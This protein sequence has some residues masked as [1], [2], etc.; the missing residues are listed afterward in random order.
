MDVVLIGCSKQKRNEKSKAIDL[1][2]SPYFVKRR[3]YAEKVIKADEVFILSAKHKLLAAETMIYPYDLSLNNFTR[4]KRR[5]WAEEVLVQ[6]KGKIQIDDEIFI[7]AGKS[8]YEFLAPLLKKEGYYNV[9]LPLK[10]KGGI[11]LQMKWLN[12]ELEKVQ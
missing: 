1:Y 9:T 12:N 3:A 6:I 4:D 5:T 10:G 2:T 8:Y 11:G 7:L